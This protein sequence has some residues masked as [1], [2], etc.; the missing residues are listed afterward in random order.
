MPRST[1]SATMFDAAPFSSS[2]TTIPPKP[3][4]ESFSPVLPS[5]RRAMGRVGVLAALR[6]LA[7]ATV[8]AVMAACLRKARRSMGDSLLSESELK[9]QRT[10]YAR[11]CCTDRELKAE[12]L[13]RELREIKTE[14]HQYSNDHANRG[15]QA[16]V[17][18]VPRRAN[19]WHHGSGEEQSARKSTHV[20]H[21]VD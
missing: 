21:V 12:R 4:M 20:S 17:E 7:D 2:I 19:A 1:A 11:Y 13:T 3:M 15:A 16:E 5:V 6:W 14:Q 8:A 9:E 10:A 18:G